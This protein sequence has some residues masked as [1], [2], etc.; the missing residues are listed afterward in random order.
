MNT[1]LKSNTNA[2]LKRVL[3]FPSLFIIAIGV[4]TAQ[5]CIVS[6]L[7]GAGAGG[8]SFFIALGIAFI[9][10]LCYVSTYAELSLMMPKAGSIS[11]YTTVAIGNFPAIIASLAGYLAPVIFGGPAELLLVDYIL[12][13]VYPGSFSHIG[14]CI[15]ILLTLFN[16]LGINLFST[17]QNILTTTMLVTFFVV[18]FVGLHPSGS[19]GLQASAIWQGFTGNNTGVFSLVIL[20]IWAFLSIEFV[21]PLIEETKL[22]E[23]NIPKTMFAAAFLILILHC[24]LAYAGMQQVNGEVLA[25]SNIPHWELVKHLFGNASKLII[26]VATITSTAGVI[27]SLIATIPRMLY[28]MAQQNQLPK[29]FLKLHRRFKTPWVG[30][31]TLSL[32]MG[33]PLFL[34]VNKKDMLATLVISSASIWLLTYIIAHVNVIVLRYTYPNAHRP[35]KSKFFP[36]LQIVGILGMGFAII[37]NAPS[38][39]MTKNIY[40]NIAIFLA[41]T[42]LYAVLWVLFKMKKRLFET[43]PME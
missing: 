8:G 37:K 15:L 6:T 27:N 2:G 19:N 5:S 35:F 11:T 18:A 1:S 34:L 25:N 20:A 10:T 40:F 36:L 31:I 24:V 42:T 33:L 22:P 28:G 30:M 29:P 23:K 43:E 16:I 41:I 14:L 38:T 9:L 4:V 26:T 13:V 21:C 7:Q 39:E 17:I 3:T 32:L 12:E